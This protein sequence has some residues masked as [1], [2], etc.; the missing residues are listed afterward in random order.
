MEDIEEKPKYRF[1]PF[2]FMNN[3]ERAVPPTD[4]EFQYFNN[5]RCC[6]ILGL[7]YRYLKVADLFNTMAFSKLTKRQQC[8]AYTSLDKHDIPFKTYLKTPPKTSETTEKIS[9]MFNVNHKAA[10]IMIDNKFIDVE[11]ALKL[12]S[13]KYEL[14]DMI[15]KT[16][17]IKKE[18]D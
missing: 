14:N 6:S 10:K 16:G 12:Y 3:R 9:K 11:A 5:Y 17:K 4:E 13:E 15:T 2:K 18:F 7:H 1:D 8:L